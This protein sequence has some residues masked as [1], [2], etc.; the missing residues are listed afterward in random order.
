M[1]LE[2]WLSH[3]AAIG[4]IWSPAGRHRDRSRMEPPQGSGL[5]NA[6]T[7]A[8]DGAAGGSE[9]GAEEDTIQDT[10]SKRGCQPNPESQ[11][12]GHPVTRKRVIV[13]LTAPGRD[14]PGEATSSVTSR[15]GASRPA[16][17][18]PQ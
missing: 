13:A 17:V 15:P 9:R 6:A 16:S 4:C 14:R 5:L 10:G 12:R 3:A 8:G 18:R 7:F 2:P 1:C 11:A